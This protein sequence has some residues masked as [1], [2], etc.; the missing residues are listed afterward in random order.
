M[1]MLA[2]RVEVVIGVDTHR[3]THTAAVMIAATGAAVGEATVCA[4]PDGYAELVAFADRFS[5]SRAWSVE[6]TGMLICRAEH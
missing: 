6:G 3:D 1:T 4:A 2:E 5:S